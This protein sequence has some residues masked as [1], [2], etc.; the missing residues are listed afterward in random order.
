MHMELIS[1]VWIFV[2]IVGGAV[3]V[4]RTHTGLYD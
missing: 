2:V 3:I 4:Y 1:A